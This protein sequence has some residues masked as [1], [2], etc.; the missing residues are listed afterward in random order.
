[1]IGPVSA[2]S[3]AGVQVTANYDSKNCSSYIQI[4]HRG[5]LWRESP[6][7]EGQEVAV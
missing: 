7:P 1:M 2:A 5:L 4:W 3:L 6:P